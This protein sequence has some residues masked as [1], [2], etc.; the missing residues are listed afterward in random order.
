MSASCTSC[1]RPDAPPAPPR[2]L[3]RPGSIKHVHAAH[4]WS[5]AP[6]STAPRPAG[7]L[8]GTTRHGQRVA[9]GDDAPIVGA[10]DGSRTGGARSLPARH[11]GTRYPIV[12]IDKFAGDAWT[13]S[14][15]T[16]PVPAHSER[17]PARVG[18][19]C[20]HLPPA[21]PPR[22][23]VRA[24]GREGGWGRAPCADEEFPMLEPRGTPSSTCWRSRKVARG[25]SASR[26]PRRSP[27][28]TSGGAL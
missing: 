10:V 26:A 4:G 9:P 20:Q 17:A 13:F 12:I 3:E 14:R 21:P 15:G 25:L 5:P 23:R 22:R 7:L 16:G 27:P 6:R 11:V 18:P 8:G 2:G 1:A 28:A 19:V 24:A